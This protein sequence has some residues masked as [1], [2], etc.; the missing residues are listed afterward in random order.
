MATAKQKTPQKTLDTLLIDHCV[1]GAILTSVEVEL[2]STSTLEVIDRAINQSKVRLSSSSL[3]TYKTDWR[4]F[5]KV[6]PV[7]PDDPQ[8]VRDWLYNTYTNLRSRA[9]IHSELSVLYQCAQELGVRNIMPDIGRPPRVK[10][11]AAHHSVDE[12]RAIIAAAKTPLQ[13]ALVALIE[14]LGLRIGE[15]ASMN[16]GDVSAQSITFRGKTFAGKTEDRELWPPQ[17]IMTSLRVLCDG[18]APGKP[19]FV[20]QRGQLTTTGLRRIYEIL[21]QQAGIPE[22]RRHPHCGRHSAGTHLIEAGCDQFTVKRLLGHKRMDQTDEYVHLA[23]AKSDKLE[24]YDPLATELKTPDFIPSEATKLYLEGLTEA[25]LL[26]QL[27][28]QLEALGETARRLKEALGS[29]GHK[30][31]KLAEIKELLEHQVNK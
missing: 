7:M 31:E 5:A 6:F 28:D 12:S 20:G 17:D 21:C 9:K 4:N 8:P 1:L 3:N 24:R 22:G 2:P 26:P 14:R 30:A 25:E 23:Q 27:L 11:A 10:K 13:L 16:V 15:V 19:L 18:R 29:N